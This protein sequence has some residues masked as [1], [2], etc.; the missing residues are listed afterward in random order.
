MLFKLISV[1]LKASASLNILLFMSAIFKVAGNGLQLKEVGGFY[2]N[3]FAEKI[4][5]FTTNLSRGTLPPISF[6]C[7]YGMGY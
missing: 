5:S 3:A 4:F 2:G 7:C 6:R 1:T